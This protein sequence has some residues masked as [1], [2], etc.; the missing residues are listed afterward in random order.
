MDNLDLMKILADLGIFFVPFLF[1]LCFHEYAH[2]LV[3]RWRGDNTAL[4]MGRLTMNP[5]A[6][7]DP[8]GTF[9][10]PI[11]AI[12]FHSP[13]FF[14]WAKPV[15]VNERNLKGKN[16][17]FWVALAG[18]L[19]N[20][21]LSLIGTVLLAVVYAHFR[22]GPAGD[23]YVRLLETFLMINMFLA[24]FNL[25]PI[26]PLD[27]GKVLAPFLPASWNIWLENNQGTL[28]MALLLL[29]MLGGRVLAMPVYFASEHLRQLAISLAMAMG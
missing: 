10:L 19:S 13:F 27:G 15:P 3:A 1:A 20:I 7:A 22:G 2:G 9:V 17:M 28:N 26:H 18:P 29:L 12:A 23:A 4:M 21:L 6:H 5:L 24:I 8:L 16:D 14:G 11:A 25:I